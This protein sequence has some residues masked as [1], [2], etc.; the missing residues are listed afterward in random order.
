MW[1]RLNQ[2]LALVV[3]FVAGICNGNAE[4]RAAEKLD[5]LIVDGQNNHDWHVMTPYM[6]Q[7]LEN[8]GR[9]TVDVVTTPPK[10]APAAAWDAF[11]PEFSKYDAVLSNYNGQPWP[12]QVQKDLTAY[13]KGGGG[14]VI[15]HA[16][17][18]AFPKWPQWNEMIGLG[19]RGKEFGERVALDDKGKIQRVSAGKGPGAGHGRQHEYAIVTRDPDH[20][21]TRGMPREW[22]HTKDELYHGQRGPALNMQILATAFSD[23]AT[24]GTGTHEPMVWVIPYGKGRVFTTVLGHVGG[25]DITSLRCIGFQTVMNRGC[26]WAATGEVTLPIPKNFPKPD[27]VSVDPGK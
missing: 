26:E 20:P 16:A 9:F 27:V 14:L 17:N 11:L 18:N 4:L 1:Y 13:V 2:V 6:S 22:M 3:L 21:V 7:V 15:I 25:E 24:G 5:I 23:K 19:W 8:T 12:Q 10:N